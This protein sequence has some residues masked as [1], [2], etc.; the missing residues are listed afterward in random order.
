MAFIDLFDD[1]ADVGKVVVAVQRAIVEHF[2]E[3]D[4]T[5][6]AYESGTQ[7]YLLHHKRLLRSLKWRDDD[8]GACVFEVL[9]R[10]AD[11]KVSVFQS[12]ITHP[13]I[14]P[15]VERD[16]GSILL[17]IGISTG[18]VA[19]ITAETLAAPDVV[20]R[21]L[22]DADTLL[23]TSG[24]VSCIDRLHTALH[25]YFRSLCERAHLNPP[26]GTS[27][28]AL[29]KLLR[30]QHPLFQNLGPQDQD[31]GRVLSGFASV[32]DALNT[33]RNNASV[34]HPNNELIGEVEGHLMVNAVRTIFHY[35]RMKVG[36]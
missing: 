31:V 22:V 23:R 33:I 36:E 6:F 21:A 2:T 20:A 18:H 27:L 24:S 4:W 16:C 26:D 30:T 32:V 17:R 28:P 8:Y 10:F 1:S 11:E 13:K 25:G 19:P 3:V 9:R 15:H 7:D 34:A 12:L 5:Q 35:L 29:Y 14:Q